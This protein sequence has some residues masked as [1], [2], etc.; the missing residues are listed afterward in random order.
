MDCAFLAP[1][2]V[3]VLIVL[4]GNPVLPLVEHVHVRLES[5]ATDNVDQET[6]AMALL[7]QDAPLDSNAQIILVP[8]HSVIMA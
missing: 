6:A 3:A 2:A 7:S 5:S 1:H 8:L 4:V